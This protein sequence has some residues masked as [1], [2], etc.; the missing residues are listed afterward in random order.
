MK[1]VEITDYETNKTLTYEYP[2]TFHSKDEIFKTLRESIIRCARHKVEVTWWDDH[3]EKYD[4]VTCYCSSAVTPHV[5]IIPACKKDEKKLQS[6]VD[7]Y[8]K[9]V[10]DF[11]ERKAMPNLSYI[12]EPQGQTLIIN[13]LTVGHI[14]LDEKQPYPYWVVDLYDGQ[15]FRYE[16]SQLAAA[17]K[18]LEEK[19]KDLL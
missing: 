10:K 1:K 12:N 17:R 3:K 2:H 7:T 14:T 16:L 15:N 8:N 13:S 5:A 6:L 18:F 4:F 11:E 19:A 9:C